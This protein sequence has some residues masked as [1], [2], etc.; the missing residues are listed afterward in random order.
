MT[1]SS[2][3]FQQTDNWYLYNA[4]LEGGSGGG[5]ATAT[6][7]DTQIAQQSDID[8][9]SVFK[10]NF[11]GR[12]VLKDGAGMSVFKDLSYVSHF[13]DG[14]NNV[15]V[16]KKNNQKSVFKDESDG[17]SWLKKIT[18]NTNAAGGLGI[19]SWLAQLNGAIK[20]TQG[21]GVFSITHHINSA[22]AS[23]LASDIQ[24]Y[25]NGNANII[26]VQQSIVYNGATWDAFLT[27]VDYSSI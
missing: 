27:W 11:D 14:S 3:Q 23:A 9:P 12:S 2:D 7:Q 1:Y 25:L 6:N 4:I 18:D 26:L 16:F 8:S 10:D 5:D 20:N 15:S 19:A 24:T 22:T 13:A 21:R 17:E